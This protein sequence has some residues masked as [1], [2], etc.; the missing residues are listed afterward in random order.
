MALRIACQNL[1]EPEDVDRVG[2]CRV[3]TLDATDVTAAI[4][5]ASDA[6]ARLAHGWTLGRCTVNLRPCRD[7]CVGYPCGCCIL[8]GIKL[9]GMAPA[10][11][12]VWVDGALVDPDTYA[13]ITR[14]GGDKWLER[15]NLDGTPAR[16]PGCQSLG[17]AVD[18]EGTFQVTVEHGLERDMLMRWAA[19]EIAYDILEPLVAT[20]NSLEDLP[21]G[22]QSI[23][24]YSMRLSMVRDVAGSEG[25]EADRLAGLGHVKRFLAIYPPTTKVGSSVWAPEIADTYQHFVVG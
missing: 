1:C 23:D 12:E 16:W 7:S 20:G 17:L 13:V 24:A 19:A 2:G 10:V 15:F 11:T 21:D 9:E 8:R 6:L 25:V 14:P 22:V 4:E 18:Q 3:E 5:A